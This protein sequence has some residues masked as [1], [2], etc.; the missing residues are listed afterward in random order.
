MGIFSDGTLKPVDVI[1]EAVDPVQESAFLGSIAR[2]AFC[3]RYPA[4][5]QVKFDDRELT[6]Y[7]GG[8]GGSQRVRLSE[9]L[10]TSN[11]TQSAL[12]IRPEGQ[13]A[14]Y[15]N[16]QLEQVLAF[17]LEIE[18]GSQWLIQ[19]T[20]AAENTQLL[21]RNLTVYSGKG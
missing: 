9:E 12:E 13:M 4:Q 5:E 8:A 6:V 10:D 18:R 2:R 21:V 7:V 11:W 1:W 20:G 15:V 3:L 16:Q 17:P 14:L 19:L